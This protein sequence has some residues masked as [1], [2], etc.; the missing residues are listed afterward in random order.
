MSDS[1]EVLSAHVISFNKSG[2]ADACAPSQMHGGNQNRPVNAAEVEL[3][4]G[5]AKMKLKINDP[6]ITLNIYHGWERTCWF[7]NLLLP[8]EFAFWSRY[9]IGSFFNRKSKDLT[10]SA[11]GPS[12]FQS[13]LMWNLVDLL[14]TGMLYCTFWKMSR[15]SLPLM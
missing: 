9:V 4:T 2:R 12:L 3:S 13:A 14:I 1:S 5:F 11:C 15:R 8:L 6:V 10:Y 7:Y